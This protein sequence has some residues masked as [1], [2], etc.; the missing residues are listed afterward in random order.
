MRNLQEM[1][2]IHYGSTKLKEMI[3]MRD[4]IS[5]LYLNKPY[6]GLWASPI[7]SEYFTWKDWC[8]GECYRECNEDN[9]FIFKIKEGSNILLL[10][11]KEDLYKVK[12]YIIVES[13]FTKYFD[14]DKI[15]DQYNGILL[16]HG[17]NYGYF[18][19]IFCFSGENNDIYRGMFNSWDCDSI[20]I[21]NSDA[22]EV[23]EK[24]S[25][26]SPLLQ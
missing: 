24:L 22:I 15:M 14:Y 17:N 3:E 6:K 25:G 10:E 7:G 18:H 4:K 26:V 9:S 20:V 19:D 13:Q 16:I 23:E 21:W 12:D 8:E 11:S 1:R 5:C 2:F